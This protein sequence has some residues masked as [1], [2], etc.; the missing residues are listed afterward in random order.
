MKLLL[1]LL[2]VRLCSAQDYEALYISACSVNAQEEMA[3]VN[4]EVAFYLDFEQKKLVYTTPKFAGPVHL[5]VFL[6]LFTAQQFICKENMKMF[7]DNMKDFSLELDPPSVPLLYPK[8][9]PRPSEPNTLV[10]HTSGFYP[11][12][13]HFY[14][15]K[16]GQNVTHAA[17]VSQAYPQSDG[18]F[19]QISRLDLV[20]EDGQVYSCGV[21]HPSLKGERRTRMWTVQLQRPSLAP[22]VFCAVGLTLG[23]VA[24]VL[25][26]F[27]LVK[28]KR[29]S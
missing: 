22:S 17:S 2:C 29:C 18:T 15:T 12:P 28:G 8:D 9:H 25:G 7:Q 4:E 24:L 6:S 16:D 20:P 5:P 13:V 27:Y 10:C 21:E 19:T 1:L 11:A 3:G 14:W 23:S 26:I